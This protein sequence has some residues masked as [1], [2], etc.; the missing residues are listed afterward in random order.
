[1]PRFI[2]RLARNHLSTGESLTCELGDEL[3]T[4]ELFGSRCEV[5]EVGG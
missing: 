2:G 4:A 1:M 5:C 3:T